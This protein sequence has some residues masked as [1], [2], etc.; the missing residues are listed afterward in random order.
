MEWEVVKRELR[1]LSWANV[2]STQ[3][4]F[5]LAVNGK[6]EPSSMERPA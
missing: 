4:L 3:V 2:H 6:W 5:V 1:G